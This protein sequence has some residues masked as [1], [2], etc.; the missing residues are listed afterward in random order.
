MAC[1]LGLHLRRRGWAACPRPVP[2]WAPA[3]CPRL[4]RGRAGTP[5]RTQ[6]GFAELVLSPAFPRPL[7]PPESLEPPVLRSLAGPGAPPIAGWGRREAG[8]GSGRGVGS[9][10]CSRMSPAPPGAGAAPCWVDLP[11]GTEAH[12]HP[13]TPR[14]LAANSRSLF[15]LHTHCPSEPHLAWDLPL[16]FFRA[17]C[18]QGSAPNSLSKYFKVNSCLYQKSPLFDSNQ[19]RVP[20]G[21]SGDEE[22]GRE[23]DSVP[24][25]NEH[26]LRLGESSAG[27]G[28]SSAGWGVTGL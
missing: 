10:S 26:A 5:A 25:S 16:T 21:V 22:Y 3:V 1:Q 2:R 18:L 9:W 8:R 11:R 4:G 7:P 20:G 24:R 13:V 14:V 15:L 23:A 17:A 19:G 28:G 27:R 12:T 6:F